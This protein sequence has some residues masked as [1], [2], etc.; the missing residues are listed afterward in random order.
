[1]RT[2]FFLLAFVTSASAQTWEALPSMHTPR[3]DA[4]VAVLD[5]K[6]YVMGGTGPGGAVLGTAERYDPIPNAWEII[7]PLRDARTGAAA[8]VLNGQIVLIGGREAGGEVTDDAEAYDPAQNDWESFDSIEIDREHLGAATLNGGIYAMGGVSEGG[9]LLASCEYYDT[10]WSI[11]AAWTVQPPRADFGLASVGDALILAGGFSTFGPLDTVERYVPNQGPTPLAPLPVAKGGLAFAATEAM[12]WA[13]GGRDAQDGVRTEVHRL[14]FAS[15]T[16][17][18]APPLP[19]AREDARAVL[20][21]EDLVVVGG[22]DA[23]GT[24]LAS[25][26][27]LRGVITP[28]EA[29]PEVV[30]VSLRLAGTHPV[31]KSARLD[32]EVEA[33]GAVSVRVYDV[34]GRV[35]ATLA[36]QTLAAGTHRLEWDARAAAPGLYLA[37][38]ATP[39]GTATLRLTVA[40]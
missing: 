13:I 9:A 10:D 16:W 36:D 21:G 8:T 40:R 27:T 33:P 29:D 32:A 5:G 24:P 38:L 3:T 23:F 30:A 12:A 2:L 20:L 15:N 11:Y 18:S 4:A 1:M 31:R 6:L 22:R 39:D 37:R 35:V 25:A 28:H 34:R 17:T 26:I 7:E 19:A 14:D